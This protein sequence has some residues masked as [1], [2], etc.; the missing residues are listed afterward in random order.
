MVFR[1]PDRLV[2]DIPQG[3]LKTPIAHRRINVSALGV[4]RVRTAQFK[5]DPLIVWIVVDMKSR[6]DFEIE[7]EAD[8]LIVRLQV[9]EQGRFAPVE[10]R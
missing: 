1:S 8:R 6:L 10:G 4:Q 5:N 2:I 3:M 9:S 7:A